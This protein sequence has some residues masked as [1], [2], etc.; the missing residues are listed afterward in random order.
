MDIKKEIKLVRINSTLRFLRFADKYFILRTISKQQAKAYRI[1][2][3]WGV[4]MSSMIIY[5]FSLQN[6]NQYLLG[7]LFIFSFMVTFYTGLIYKLKAVIIIKPL[8]RWFWEERKN[9]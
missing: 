1:M 8:T 3:F 6:Y 9:A 4:I 5:T 2:C 7:I